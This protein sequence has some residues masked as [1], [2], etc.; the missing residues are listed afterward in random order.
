[1]LHSTS[2]AHFPHHHRLKQQERG[3]LFLKK[4][5]KNIKRQR[6]GVDQALSLEFIYSL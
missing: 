5:K 6:K 1:M 4:R 2:E 3:G